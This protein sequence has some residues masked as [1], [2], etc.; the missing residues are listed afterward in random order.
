MS[1]KLSKSPIANSK[2]QEH[3]HVLQVRRSIPII[4]PRSANHGFAGA[5]KYDREPTVGGAIVGTGPRV[6]SPV[7]SSAFGAVTVLVRVVVGTALDALPPVPPKAG[8]R[9][10]KYQED[11]ANLSQEARE[12]PCSGD[13]IR[14]C[15]HPEAIL[16][17]TV[18]DGGDGNA[19]GGWWWRACGTQ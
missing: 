10:G 17:G 15:R 8:S 4:L 9:D 7:S 12:P 14:G 11:I 19:G 13:G 3:V 16:T 2:P 5:P 18:C 6:S 1:E